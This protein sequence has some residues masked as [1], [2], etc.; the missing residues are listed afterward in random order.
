MKRNR[1]ITLITLVVTIIIMLILVGVAL[2]FALGDNDIINKSKSA[3]IHSDVA[4]EKELLVQSAA[5]AKGKSEY[6]D[7]VPALMILPL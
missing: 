3:K 5:T 4:Q 2:T 6:G 7:V 1:G